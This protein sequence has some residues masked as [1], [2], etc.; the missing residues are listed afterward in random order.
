MMVLPL[1]IH[2]QSVTHNQDALHLDLEQTRYAC[3]NA[4]FDDQLH[5]YSS[6]EQLQDGAFALPSLAYV[7]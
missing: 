6:N 5:E 1:L 4:L 3:S 2:E 7:R